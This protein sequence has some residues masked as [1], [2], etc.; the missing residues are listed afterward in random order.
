ML[1]ELTEP[2]NCRLVEIQTMTVAIVCFHSFPPF[3]N[4]I[5]EK[6]SDAV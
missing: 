3:Q 5:S 2:K 6:S 1:R 4:K